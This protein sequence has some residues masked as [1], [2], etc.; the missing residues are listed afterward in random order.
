MM[1]NCVDYAIVFKAQHEERFLNVF[2]ISFEMG[3][4]AQRNKPSV[5]ESFSGKIDSLNLS[6]FPQQFEC[7]FC[8]EGKSSI[9]NGKRNL[10]IKLNG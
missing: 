8:F 7:S 10:E 6:Q 3:I 1:T 9:Q 5:F 4:D 2:W